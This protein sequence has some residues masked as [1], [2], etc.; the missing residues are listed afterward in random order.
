[1]SEMSRDGQPSDSVWTVGRV[2]A[3]CSSHF[4]KN[5]IDSPR[6][7]SELILS[8][9]LSLPRIRVYAEHKREMTPEQLTRTRELVKR[10]IAH[11]PIQYLTGCA[12]FFG[13]E[14]RV[15][16]D[17]LI[18]RG[19]T[20]TLVEQA[21]QFLR[22]RL[23]TEPP[24]VLDL[25]TGSGCVAAAIAKQVKQAQVLAIDISAAAVLIARENL[26]T[27]KLDDRVSVEIGDLFEPVS[28]QVDPRPF[29]LIASNPPY[30]ATPQLEHLDKNVRDY[31][32]RLALDGGSDGHVL[33]R[34][35]IAEA[36]A[37]LV[38]GG[39]LLMEIAFDQGESAVALFDS[40][41]WESIK[42]TNDLSRNPRVVGASKATA[43]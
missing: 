16:P 2:M 28:R 13:M 25:C 31:E 34:R 7:S 17:V 18:P 29:D 9:V 24:R 35:I 26:K 23:G 1:M 8:H 21:L 30:I 12:P 4:E 42:L 10:A 19:D 15:T 32:P 20:E 5:K 36:Q 33:H 39:R 40:A 22:G 41:K 27:F 38:P 3:W 6:L 43:S 14:F 11:E 37:H